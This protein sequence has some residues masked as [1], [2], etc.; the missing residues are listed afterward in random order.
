MHLPTRAHRILLACLAL[1]VT[2]PVRAMEHPFAN[3]PPI[4]TEQVALSASDGTPWDLFGFSVAM[5]GDTA[6]VGAPIQDS[7]GAA[8][9]GAAYVFVRN[10]S[11]WQEQARLLPSG[12]SLMSFFGATVAISGDTVLVG[13]MHSTYVFVRNGTSWSEQARLLP[14]GGTLL[15]IGAA[16]AVSGDTAVA[17]DGFNGGVYLFV[18]SGTSWSEQAR[19]LP[20]EPDD[21]F[22]SSLA[23]SGDTLVVGAPGADNRTGAVYVFVR[24]GS[25]W[26]Q[27]ARLAGAGSL[28]Q[29]N[30]GRSISISG[31]RIAV[32]TWP[33]GGSGGRVYTFVRS[34]STW[35]QEATLAGSGGQ[36]I[37]SSVSISDDLLITGAQSAGNMGSAVVFIRRGSAWLERMLLLPSE[38]EVM[39]AFGCSVTLSGT[40]AIVGK[41]GP[42]GTE[43]PGTA[44]VFSLDGVTVTP[45]A[46]LFTTEDGGTATFTATLNTPPA[47]DV[48]IDLTSADPG[49]GTVSP[50]QLTFTPDDWWTAQTVTLAGVDDFDD[51]AGQTYAVILTMNTALTEDAVYD[52]IDPPDVSAVNLPLE[53]VFYTLTP[54]RALDTRL[55]E[56]E[57]A[58]TGGQERVVML[59]GTCGVP[60]T[61]RAVALNV[62]VVNPTAAGQLTLHPSDLPRPPLSTLVF[63]A[64]QNRANDTVVLLAT[65]GTGTLT[66][67]PLLESGGSAHLILDV[68]GYFE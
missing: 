9:G 17:S 52:G 22:G 5:S 41:G 39:D 62:T 1:A 58:L 54:C 55:P 10:G 23:L 6:V 34:G 26:T 11:S 42:G 60:V 12:V 56:H 47:G 36:A 13:G 30:F 24:S 68:S 65:S 46:G 35:S 14:S 57:P 44:Y 45:T 31:E 21:G 18:R 38:R 66:V 59:Q 3:D 63:D 25:A 29:D 67:W 48:V 27:Q 19:L 28:S 33:Q 4:L 15:P 7:P 8:E 51:D 61:A 37:G 64:G 40:V 20:P 50:T 16:I 49:E 32:G 53:G 2:A 43:N